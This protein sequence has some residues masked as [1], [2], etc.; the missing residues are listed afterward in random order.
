MENFD[1]RILTQ[2]VADALNAETSSI[3]L[4]KIKTGR[5]NSSWAVDGWSESLIL[6]IAPE[7]NRAKMLFYEHR[8]ILQEPSIL[9]LIDQK[10]DIPVPEILTLTER[11]PKIHRDWL[12][13]TQLPGVP[14][15][16]AVLDENALRDIHHQIGESLRKIHNLNSD[17]FGY[18]GEHT[19]MEGQPTWP[20]AFSIMWNKLIDDIVDVEGYSLEEAA[21]MRRLLESFENSIPDIQHPSLLHMDL[22]HENILVANNKELSG[23]IDWDRAL[24]GDPALDLT[25]CQYCGLASTEFFDGYSDERFKQ[26]RKDPL[27]KLYLLYEIQKYIFI[28]RARRSEPQIADNY[29][30]Q[31]LAIARSLF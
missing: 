13:M 16:H 21:A 22:W 4:K 25:I 28:N 18:L 23:L 5:F 11:D 24:W 17:K 20:Q 15:T 6:R 7:E 8:M 9:K 10:T 30:K 14:M 12:L 31:C 2:I 27:T 29:K 3:R 19:P 26:Q 1:P